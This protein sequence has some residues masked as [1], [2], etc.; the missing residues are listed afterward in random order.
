ME[1]KGR[2]KY[3]TAQPDGTYILAIETRDFAHIRQEYDEL[4]QANECRIKVAKWAEKRSK[5]ANAYFH[6]LVGKIAEKIERSNAWVKNQLI[7]EWGQFEFIGEHIAEIETE[8]P[9][10]QMLELT[11]THVRLDR[12]DFT[13][14][15]ERYVYQL[16]RG[17]HTY[18]SREMARLIDGAVQYCEVLGIEHKTQE[19]IERLV[20]LWK[21][22]Y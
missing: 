15:G 11:D 19:E 10:E 22:S 9:P 18:D 5:D 14:S 13:E 20:E 16:M 6:V 2:I 17:S 21:R 4:A 7:G 8:V 12:M 1:F 3:C